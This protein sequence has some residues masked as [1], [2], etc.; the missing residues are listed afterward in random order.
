[1]QTQHEQKCSSPSH[2][3]VRSYLYFVLN[4]IMELVLMQLNSGECSFNNFFLELHKIVYIL[5][6]LCPLGSKGPKC[7]YLPFKLENSDFVLRY[8][9]HIDILL[10]FKTYQNKVHK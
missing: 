5:V 4:L 6:I 8:L 10:Q 7:K 3:E 1:M 9:Q 2:D